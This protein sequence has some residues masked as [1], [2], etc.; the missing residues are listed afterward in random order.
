MHLQKIFLYKQDLSLTALNLL[1]QVQPHKPS[2][3]GL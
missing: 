3:F 1:F 2:K